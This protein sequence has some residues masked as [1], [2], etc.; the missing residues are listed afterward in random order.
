MSTKLLLKGIGIAGIGLFRLI[1]VLLLIISSIMVAGLISIKLGL[2]GYYWW[3]A[4]IVIFG[5]LMKIFMYNT[6]EENYEQ[7]VDNYN[8]EVEEEEKNVEMW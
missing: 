4:S 8:K 5:L 6:S 7:L 1:Y 2:T 3:F